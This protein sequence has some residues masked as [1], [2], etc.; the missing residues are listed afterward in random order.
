MPEVLQNLVLKGKIITADA[1]HTQTADAMHTQRET[2]QT[3][4]DGDGDYVIVVCDS[5]ER[6]SA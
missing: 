3:I 4:V 6:Q 2:C 1:M 5:S